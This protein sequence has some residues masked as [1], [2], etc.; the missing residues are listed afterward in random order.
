M[1]ELLDKL[2]QSRTYVAMPSGFAE[3]REPGVEFTL[4]LTFSFLPVHHLFA[5]RHN[6]QVNLCVDLRHLTI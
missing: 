6:S 3:D 4:H 2:R 1:A 5:I